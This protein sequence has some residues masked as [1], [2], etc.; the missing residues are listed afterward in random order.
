M[1]ASVEK[2]DGQWY[3]GNAGSSSAKYM[4]DVMKG[5]KCSEES[6]ERMKVI[7]YEKFGNQWAATNARKK[8]LKHEKK[9]PLYAKNSAGGSAEGAG[10]NT[11]LLIAGG[12]VLL[13][14]LKGKK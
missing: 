3:H 1:W 9:T 14:L 5:C 6:I 7:I 12:L 4:E 13:L 8:L 11:T 2:R 10:S